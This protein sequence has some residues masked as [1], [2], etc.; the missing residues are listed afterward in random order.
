MMK[1]KH[2]KS[3]IL[4]IAIAAIALFSASAVAA[5]PSGAPN[6][7]Q[8]LERTTS[9][10]G[11]ARCITA[12]F[13]MTANG[14]TAKGTLKMSGD[15]FFLTLPNASIWYDG[16]TLWSLD[17]STKEVNISE[18]MPEEL[19]Q[20]K[21]K[22]IISSLLNAAT[23]RQMKGTDK[24]YALHI[25]PKVSQRLAFTSAMIDVDKKTFL[26]SRIVLTL[27]SGQTVTLNTDNINLTTNHPASTFVFNKSNYPGYTLIDLR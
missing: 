17:S 7:H 16:R 21:P 19:A 27:D 9:K 24:D 26:P 14:H 10:I 20:I 25:T 8:I 5:S 11:K 23:P 1:L 22:I 2:Y 3:R 6:A 18:P 15:K 12:S 13:S 4:S